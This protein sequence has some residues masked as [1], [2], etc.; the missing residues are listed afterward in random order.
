VNAGTLLESRLALR[1]VWAFNV[2]LFLGVGVGLIWM[3]GSSEAAA[4][5]AAA[6]AFYDQAV[7]NEAEVRQ[8]DRLRVLERRLRDDLR[9]ITPAQGAAQETVDVVRLLASEAAAHHVDIRGISPGV[10]DVT[11]TGDS[12]PLIPVRL[13]VSLRGRFANVVALLSD[14]PRHRVLVEVDGITLASSEQRTMV[15]L[16]DVTLHATLFRVAKSMHLEE[17]HVAA[18]R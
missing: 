7:R 2:V 16:L 12:G 5:D 1:A 15:P 3:P 18:D 9:E 11:A 6:R 14:I 17:R 10:P 8:A 4:L 13:D